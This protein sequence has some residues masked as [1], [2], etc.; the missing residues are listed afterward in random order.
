M[1]GL[2][3]GLGLPEIHTRVEKCGKNEGH[4]SFGTLFTQQLMVRM[5]RWDDLESFD[6]IERQTR[7]L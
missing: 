4:S 3:E 7:G 6:Q 2:G 1:F 5:L